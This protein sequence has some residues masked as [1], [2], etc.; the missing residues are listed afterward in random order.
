MDGKHAGLQVNS[1]AV[2]VEENATVTIHQG[3]AIGEKRLGPA[4]P[5][6]GYSGFYSSRVHSS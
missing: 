1:E 4:N 5:L 3:N 2:D 6:R